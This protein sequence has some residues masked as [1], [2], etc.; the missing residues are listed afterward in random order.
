MAENGRAVLVLILEKPS[1]VENDQGHALSDTKWR[2][3]GRGI[4]FR[5][6]SPSTVNRR[7]I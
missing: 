3:A 6:E 2:I 4:L 1:L 7:G 5:G